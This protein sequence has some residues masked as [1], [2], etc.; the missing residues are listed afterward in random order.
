VY[1]QTKDNRYFKALQLTCT[2]VV[3]IQTPCSNAKATRSKINVN[4]QMQFSTSADHLEMAF[5]KA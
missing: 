5:N 3:N 2:E 1:T 4:T